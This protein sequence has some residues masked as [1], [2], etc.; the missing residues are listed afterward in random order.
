MHIATA[1]GLVALFIA[2][3]SPWGGP[4]E[5][6]DCVGGCT[7]TTVNTT[8][9]FFEAPA[10]T[11]VQNGS[12]AGYRPAGS[13]ERSTSQ[14]EPTRSLA[15]ALPDVRTSSTVLQ[16]ETGAVTTTVA[17]AQICAIG[18][19]ID[20]GAMTD[21][22][23][24]ALDLLNDATPLVELRPMDN[25]PVNVRFGG[26]WPTAPAPLGWTSGDGRQILINPDHPFAGEPAIITEIVS[27]EL[28]HVLLGPAHV[29]DGS[30]LDPQLNGQVMLSDSDRTQLSSIT[31]P[32]LGFG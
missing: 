21:A 10:D 27:H 24:A 26:V 8:T 31:C 6:G 25:G 9:E 2:I 30:L 15:N 18:F 7:D 29:N 13:S 22:A 12:L 3:L 5:D 11:R 4:A 1:G 20:L 28:G 17:S 14:P 16:R 32:E 19:D 23:V